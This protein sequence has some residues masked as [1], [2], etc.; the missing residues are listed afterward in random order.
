MFAVRPHGH[1]VAYRGIAMLLNYG[2]VRPRRNV[3]VAQASMVLICVSTRVARGACFDAC[4]TSRRPSCSPCDRPFEETRAPCPLPPPVDFPFKPLSSSLIGV[5]AEQEKVKSLCQA[6]EAEGQ[7][8][9]EGPPQVSASF[10]N[11]AY[12]GLIMGGVTHGCS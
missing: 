3:S 9:A 11:Q 4:I 10:R 12:S 8:G 7:E 1:G 6:Q 2:P 5:P